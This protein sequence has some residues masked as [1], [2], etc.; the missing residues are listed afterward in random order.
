MPYQNSLIPISGRMGDHIYYY[1]K[2]RK[3]RKHYFIRQAPGIVKQ[4]L[5]T[6]RAAADFGT[7][8]KSSGLLRKALHQYT[9]F[10]YDNSLHFRLN[11][12]MGEILRAD[13]N[14]PS[15]Q[16]VLL[17][18]NMKSLRHFQFNRDASIDQL[19]KSTPVVEKND[20]GDISVSLPS[21]FSHNSHA[22]RNT[23]H[24]TVK[25]IGLSVN[26]AKGTTRKVILF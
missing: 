25:A 2:D 10:C 13:V 17:A 21:T 12:K 18:A 1:R 24:I 9:R 7:A 26:F 22:L 16:R 14:R 3:N 4:T 19:L 23:T 6:K 20:T 5:A 11:K 15:G 8:S